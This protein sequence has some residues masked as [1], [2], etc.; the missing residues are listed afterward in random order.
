MARNDPQYNHR[1]DSVALKEMLSA[2]ASTNGRSL[3]AE[4]NARLK[5]SFESGSEAI[6][7]HDVSVVPALLALDSKVDALC[8]HLGVKVEI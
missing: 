1:F 5:Q 4:I 6:V 2:A 3:T 7:G 8:R